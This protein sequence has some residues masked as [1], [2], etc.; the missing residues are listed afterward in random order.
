MNDVAARKRASEATAWGWGFAVTAAVCLALFGVNLAL[1]DVN[2]AT[3][4][5]MSYGIAA[6][7]FLVGAAVYGARRRSMQRSGVP[8]MRSGRRNRRS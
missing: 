7:I 4:L 1:W 3:P 2:P 6:A 8:T 5:G